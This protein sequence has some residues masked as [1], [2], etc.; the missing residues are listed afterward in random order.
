MKCPDCGKNVRGLNKKDPRLMAMHLSLAHKAPF[1]VMINTLR[2]LGYPE[3][4]IEQFNKYPELNPKVHAQEGGTSRL[5][6]LLRKSLEKSTG[7]KQ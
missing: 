6:V 2:C 5:E 4:E 7:D 1:S 3:E